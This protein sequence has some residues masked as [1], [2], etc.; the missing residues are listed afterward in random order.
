MTDVHAAPDDRFGSG[1]VDTSVGNATSDGGSRR[2][3]PRATRAEDYESGT[4][5][6]L[7]GLL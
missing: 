1:G 6:W 2:D 4:R 5:G 7:V 3:E